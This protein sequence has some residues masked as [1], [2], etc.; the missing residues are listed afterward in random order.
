MSLEFNAENNNRVVRCCSFCRRAGHTIASC[1]SMPI[2]LFERS[3]SNFIRFNIYDGVTEFRNFIL[4]ETLQN[5]N[6]VRAFAIRRCGASAVSNIDI[7]IE[8]IVRYFTPQIRIVEER[9]RFNEAMLIIDAMTR[10]NDYLI[11][12]QPKTFDIKTNITEMK[13]DFEELCECNICYEQREKKL[14]AKLDC[15]HEFCKD[16]T[17]KSL[18]NEKRNI[19]CCAFCRNQIKNIELKLETLKEEFEEFIAPEFVDYDVD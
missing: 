16:C 8:L 4:E 18:Q 7:C 13:E 17:I 19:P 6:V 5:S 15:G 11:E 14:F 10:V 12:T 2:I 9:T 3:C 1:D